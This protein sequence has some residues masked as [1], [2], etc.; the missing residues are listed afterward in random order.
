[1]LYIQSSACLVTL[2]D[3]HS[4]M[5]MW[6]VKCEQISTVKA[7]SGKGLGACNAM[8]RVSSD[9]MVTSVLRTL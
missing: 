3:V 8:A 7:S 4:A 2:L 6:I 9:K 1:M 5:V